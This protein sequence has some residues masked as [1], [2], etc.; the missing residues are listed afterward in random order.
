MDKFLHSFITI[1]KYIQISTL[2]GL[3]LFLGYLGFIDHRS[4]RTPSV[5]VISPTI[6][7]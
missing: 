2:V 5:P 6:Q 1:E 3:L 4:V 7:R